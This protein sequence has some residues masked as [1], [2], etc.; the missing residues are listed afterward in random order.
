MKKNIPITDDMSPFWA[1]TRTDSNKDVNM[2]IEAFCFDVLP[3]ACIGCKVPTPIKKPLWA[4]SL[5]CA[6]NTKKISRG[7]VL[8]VSLMRADSDD[9]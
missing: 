9:E 5:Q 2:Q 3:M 8:C 4:V 1:L 6:R 7:E